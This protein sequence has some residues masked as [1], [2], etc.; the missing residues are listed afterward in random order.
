MWLVRSA[1]NNRYAVS[2][3]AL[4]IVVLG[5]V[6]ATT[7]PVDI[8]P[9]FRAPAVQVM[10][11]Y[12]GMPAGVVEKNI[13]NRLERWTGQANGT[14]LQESKSMVGVSIIRSYFGD[15]TDPNSALTQVN[16]LAL[17]NLRYLPPG[18]LPPIVL[19]FDPTATMPIA[20]LS[21]SSEELGEGELQ[22]VARY[23]LRNAVQSVSGAVA[24]AVFGG[25]VRAVLAYVDREKLEAR[26]LSPMDV[27]TAIGNYNIML[28][29]GGA[30]I[31]DIDYQIDSNSMMATPAD[32]DFIPLK[33]ESGNAV[34]LRDVGHTQDANRI[35][36]GLVRI[37][38]RRQVYVPVYRQQ[39]AST[40]AVV[41][42]VKDS[43]PTMQERIP[44]GIDLQ[45]VMD[46]SVY[47]RAAI[48]SLVY[49]GAFGAL[50]AGAMILVFL[51]SLRSTAIATVSIAL[52]ILAAIAG[53]MA[54]GNTINA[55][56]LGG[57]ALAVG[58]LVNNAIVV[59]E[60]THRH[61]GMGKTPLAAASDGANEV[62]LPVFVATCTTIIVL[63]PISFT[64]GMGTFLFRPMAL[65]VAFAMVASYILSLTFV[66][67]RCANWLKGQPLDNGS[68][69][70]GERGGRIQRV[71]GKMLGG[72]I[73]NYEGLLGRVLR[74]RLKVLAG[75][76]LLFLASLALFPLLGQELF[77]QVDAG[78]LV[79]TMR[80][81]TGTRLETTE[82]L[83]AKV[84][85]ALREHI[86]PRDLNMIISELGVVPDWSAAYT[87]NS[88]PQDAVLKVQLTDERT[89]TAQV[90]AAELR[91]VLAEKFPGNE[92]AFN[93]G[94]IVSAALNYG[95]LSPINV[96]IAG[97]ASEKARQLAREIWQAVRQVPGAV[98][99]RISQRFDYPQLYIEVDRTKAAELGLTQ[100]DVIQN[101]VTCLNSSIQFARNFW[102]DP[103][104]GNQYWVGVQFNEAA[105]DS[106]DTLLNV[107]ITSPRTGAPVLLRNL[108]KLQ[109]T[110]APAEITHANFSPVIEIYANAS[111]R[112]VG[113]VARDIE[114]AIGKLD[115]PEGVT[116]RMSGE[117]Q[118]MRTTFGSMGFGL[119]IA[120]VL[121][122][123][124]MVAL[125][126]SYVDPLVILFVVPLGLI[127]VLAT[128]YLTNTTLNVQSGMGIIFMVGIVVA[129]SVLLVDFA[130]R[131]VAEGTSP[132][133][134]IQT[135]ASI[136]LR[137][138][139]M[140]FLATFLDLLPMAI[141]VG[142]GSEANL[143]LARAVVGGL[144][145]GTAMTLFIVPI[146][147]T[148]FHREQRARKPQLMIM[149]ASSEA[150]GTA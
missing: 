104:S 18:T 32:M 125:F 74:N 109:R 89:K 121:V 118:R 133:E 12:S 132:A 101:V 103:V 61:L 76:G 11:F 146:L 6:A 10:T 141:G 63:V 129:N 40:L 108:A 131:L 70:A 56:T 94:G 46:Q 13:T 44:P 28:P 81:P 116:V 4:A 135:A 142:K 31:G 128:L 19:P 66:P 50:L 77:P 36:T 112:D 124:I 97:K 114:Q 24:P 136:R 68:T 99:V 147:Y 127:G 64:A 52:A 96:Q 22:D 51:G 48:K 39:G 47:V 3:L 38:G 62:A 25:K 58:P 54:T 8:L 120:T 53:L 27:V 67:S 7:I 145:G 37:N 134:A 16:S 149:P 1:L 23:E 126:R 17:S 88:G 69:E 49:Q 107:P 102:I 30:R 29:T 65:S 78:Q 43:I 84:E 115:T 130:N 100:Q 110:S 98:D 140:T 35:Q 75:V 119:L 93:T 55:M 95:S 41:E 21:V 106:V 34:F 60:N 148:L 105:V 123:L 92:F 26:G 14:I 79:V 5:A 122:Y 85:D 86:A 138:I 111:G 20:I 91:G 72:T 144:I 15:D 137:P 42:G 150:A 9:I 82:K 71:M 113:G 90:Y 73:R 57:L 80:V 2:V 117:V 87:P 143:P 139:L 33:A 45:V 83:V 59:L